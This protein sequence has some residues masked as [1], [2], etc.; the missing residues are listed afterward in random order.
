VYK[1]YYLCH[2]LEARTSRTI[3]NYLSLVQNQCGF[4]KK[5]FSILTKKISMFNNQQK[6]GN[7][8][9]DEISLRTSISVN[10][11]T[12]T[13]SGLE[14]YGNDMPCEHYGQKANH[15]LV[16]MFQSYAANFS[17]PIAVFTSKGPV[18]GIFTSLQQ[19]K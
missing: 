7:L 9:F 11:T 5:F 10:C 6:H 16:F 4:D 8:I 14:D 18:K 17:Q 12:L 13:Y 19:Q 3:R 2:A 15:A 1:K